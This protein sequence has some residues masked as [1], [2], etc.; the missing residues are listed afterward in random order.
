V[1]CETGA[2]LSASLAAGRPVTVDYRPSFVDGI[3][4]KTVLPRMLE[5]ARE[6]VDGVRVVT[7]DQ[8]ASAMR[9]A[10]ERNRVMCEGGAACAVAGAMEMEGT[11]AAIVSGGNIDLAKFAEI[12]CA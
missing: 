3:A 11:V 5:L 8:A 7:L 1:E 12:V 10:A 9:F 6:L 4:S 2:P